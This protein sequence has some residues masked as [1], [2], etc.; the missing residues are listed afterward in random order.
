[1]RYCSSSFLWAIEIRLR[2]LIAGPDL[3]GI[4]DSGERNRHA[5]QLVLGVGDK[6]EDRRG[7]HLRFHRATLA[8]ND[9]RDGQRKNQPEDDLQFHRYLR[10]ASR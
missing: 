8:D 10:M 1:M 7:R 9:R 4:G 2:H 6:V 3:V 5:R